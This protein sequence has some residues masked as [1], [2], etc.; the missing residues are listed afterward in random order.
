MLS[1][2]WR[3][4][5]HCGPGQPLSDSYTSDSSVSLTFSQLS[6][7]LVAGARSTPCVVMHLSLQKSCDG[8]SLHGHVIVGGDLHSAPAVQPRVT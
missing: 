4:A 1:L 2:C 6:E 7:C 3:P 8:V 5:L